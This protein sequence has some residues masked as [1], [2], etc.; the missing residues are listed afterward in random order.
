MLI[1]VL[2]A[3]AVVIALLIYVSLKPSDFHI[4]RELR[5]DAPAPVL[6]AQVNDLRKFDVWNPW[7]KLDPQAKQT[8][9]GPAS[10]VG[11]SSSWDGNPQV[12]K[13][14]MTI[15]ENVPS[16]LVRMKLEFDKPF[17]ATNVT[18]FTFKPE[19]SGT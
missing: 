17:K 11:A 12:G 5:I 7:S 9:E 8:F 13:G 19:G 10:G 6:F 14:R 3:L 15:V 16:S 18:D 1:G 2:M 4:A